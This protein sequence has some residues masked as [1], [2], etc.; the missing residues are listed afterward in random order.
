MTKDSVEEWP[1]SH[2][3]LQIK[4]YRDSTFIPNTSTYKLMHAGPLSRPQFSQVL[5]MLS[6]KDEASLL[7]A[8]AIK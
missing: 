2:S 1:C 4:V 6:V 7:D 3:V 5:K 8:Y